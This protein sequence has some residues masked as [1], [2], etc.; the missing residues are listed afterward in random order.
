MKSIY[1]DCWIV[2]LILHRTAAK[3]VTDTEPTV[4]ELSVE[5]YMV[6]AKDVLSNLSVSFPASDLDQPQILS[7]V[8][9]LRGCVLK[10]LLTP[11]KQ[12]TQ[13]R[14]SLTCIFL[15]MKIN[16]HKIIIG[17]FEDGLYASP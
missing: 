8:G 5:V 1:L 16:W 17:I 9:E 7:T 4:P 11:L 14:S 6:S 12:V 10:V 13:R 2:S 3:I 15:H